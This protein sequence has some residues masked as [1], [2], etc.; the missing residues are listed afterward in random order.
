MKFT[1]PKLNVLIEPLS[2]KW[3]FFEFDSC[4]MPHG[5]MFFSLDWTYPQLMVREL[6]VETLNSLFCLL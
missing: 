1:D 3:L 4:I 5:G 6:S 2:F